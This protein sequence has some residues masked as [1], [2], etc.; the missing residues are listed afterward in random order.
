MGSGAGGAGSRVVA[1]A[2]GRVN[3]IGDHTD[4]TGGLVMPA[5]V[6]FGT[7]VELVRGGQ[8]VVLTSDALPG[9]VDLP[10]EIHRP[11]SVEP[12]WGRYV[13]GVVSVLH[14]PAGGRGR[15]RS[16]LPVRSGLS[17]SAAL[18]VALAL[19]LGFEGPRLELARLCQQAETVAS[20]VPCGIMDQLAAA[21]GRRGHALL[22]DCGA[23]S[24]DPVPLPP[25]AIFHVVSS[26]Q[27][28]RLAASGYAA[29]RAEC[30]AAAAIIGPLSRARPEDLPRVADSKLRRRARHVITENGRVRDFAGALAAGDLAGAGK[31]MI[32][33]H[34][35]LRDDFE[36]STPVLDELVRRL[37]SRPGVFGA[38]LTGAGFGGSVVV[39]ARPDCV[40][41]G[42][43]VDASDGARV[44][45]SPGHGPAGHD[46]AHLP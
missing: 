16:T 40:P 36:V 17:S 33:S 45:R 6:Q 2:P 21:V 25:D 32:E 43:A 31:L 44:S 30:E 19:A 35:S 14:P 42:W 1:Y 37:T 23:E 3:L 10:L 27:E 9:S 8:R 34:R 39:L 38:R 13:A 46:P 5:A 15:V 26:G 18:E 20:G 11:D 28:R 22:I 4:Y 12:E 7:T 24:V 41:E 29:R